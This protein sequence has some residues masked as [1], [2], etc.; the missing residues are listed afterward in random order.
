MYKFTLF[1][2]ALFCSTISFSQNLTG[3]WEGKMDGEQFLQVNI[4]HSSKGICGFTYDY[5]INDKRSYCRAYFQ[6]S[7]NRSKQ[8]IVIAGTKFLENSG[9]HTLMNLKFGYSKEGEQE[10]LTM[11]NTLLS[12]LDRI[13]RGGSSGNFY[14]R[15]VSN[16]PSPYL[17]D[18]YEP[19][20][21]RP[22]GTL[23]RDTT[24]A[25]KPIVIVKDTPIIKKI[26]PIKVDTIVKITVPTIEKQVIERKNNVIKTIKVY[27]PTLLI[28]LYD[29]GVVDGDTISV[30]HNGKL[31]VDHQ[32]LDAKGIDV[33][34]E[35]SKENPHH[36]IVLFAHNLGSIPPNTALLVIKAGKER[37][38]LRAEADLKKNA[39][40]IFEYE[41]P[42]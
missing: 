42:K 13:S 21:E 23:K 3:T 36:E 27:S 15:K 38:E 37:Y 33:T 28:T 16:T 41:P 9:S 14:L 29:N 1:C 6:A 24:V 12:L 11:K 32:L 26:E 35:L 17:K 8:T 18:L 5:V 10:Y 22:V 25:E 2:I 31:L 19:C 20:T 7:Y 30:L 4:M 39:T 34:V 40:L